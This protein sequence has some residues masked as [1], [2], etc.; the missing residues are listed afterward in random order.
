MQRLK[1]IKFVVGVQK[2]NILDSMKVDEFYSDLGLTGDESQV[3]M[4]LHENIE[5]EL[6]NSWRRKLDHI[7]I[8]IM[9]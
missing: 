4:F 7:S 9:K 8:D 5:S 1:S 3:E 6:Q 2:K